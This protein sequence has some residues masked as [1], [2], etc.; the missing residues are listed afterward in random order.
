MGQEGFLGNMVLSLRLKNEE[1]I[2][3][4]VGFPG[5]LLV[6]SLLTGAGDTVGTSG[7]GRCPGGGNGNPFQ[8]SCLDDPINRGVW[9]ARVHGV[10]KSWTRLSTWAHRSS[11]GEIEMEH[12]KQWEAMCQDCIVGRDY[13]LFTELKKGNPWTRAA[14]S[15]VW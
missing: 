13:S 7:F 14:S 11:E 9:W 1:K 15:L 3:E 12:S 2:N 10:T 6:K 4:A 8:H 5:D